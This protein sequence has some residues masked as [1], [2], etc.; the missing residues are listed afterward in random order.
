LTLNDH[1]SVSDIA[2]FLK[3]AVI[4]TGIALD[5][6]EV[7]L[8]L[9]YKHR[10]LCKRLILVN[11]F[12]FPFPMEAHE[13]EDFL[14]QLRREMNENDMENFWANCYL[15]FG[16]YHDHSEMR[17]SAV[18]SLPYCNIAAQGAAE[19]KLK[20]WFDTRTIKNSGERFEF[21]HDKIAPA[22]K[23]GERL[24]PRNL[25]D[26][27]YYHTDIGLIAVLICFDAL[28]PRMLMRLATFQANVGNGDRDRISAIVV[29]CF[30]PNTHVRECCRLISKIMNTLVIY[31]NVQYVD[32][33]VIPTVD[34]P[35]ADAH[36]HFFRGEE[37]EIGC[38]ITGVMNVSND[39]TVKGPG[40]DPGKGLWY[41]RRFCHIDRQK[42]LGSASSSR[43]GS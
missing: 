27:N 41:S 38:N 12:G 35:R 4:E 21:V 30:S 1:L 6:Y 28:D 24:V 3:R 18:V 37:I 8:G 20:S 34:K 17:N 14:T 16:S 11:E 13:R 26:W 7:S 42:L 43:S 32:D 40:E 39:E 33:N 9:S 19:D 36:G 15:A 2:G 5:S 22:E 10:S 31:A 29:P 23:L 25:I